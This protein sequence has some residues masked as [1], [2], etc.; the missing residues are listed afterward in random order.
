MRRLIASMK[1]AAAKGDNLTFLR[2]DEEFHVGIMN[3]AGNQAAVRKHLSE[4]RR[5]LRGITERIPSAFVAGK[6]VVA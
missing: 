1:A 3:A 6:S 2:A 4:S 5:R